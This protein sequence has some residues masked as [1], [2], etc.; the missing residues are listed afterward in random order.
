MSGHRHRALILSLLIVILAGPALARA[1]SIDY[2]GTYVWS[3]PDA[4]FGGFSAIEISE[5][6]TRFHALTDRAQIRWGEIERDAEGRIRALH[7]SG[8]AVLQDSQGRMLRP[9]W[10]GDSEGLALDPL[11]GGFWVSFEG[12]DRVAYYD[13]ADAPATRLPIAEGFRDLPVNRGL[14]ALA[15]DAHGTLY[16]L[17]EL[18]PEGGDAFPVW[19]FR[20]GVWDQPFSL[21]GNSAWQ[22]VGADIGPDGRLYL[23]ERSFQGILGFRSRIRRFSLSETGLSDEETLLESGRLQYDNLEGISAWDDGVGIRLTMISDDNF[24]SFQRTELV[25]YRIRD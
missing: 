3:L 8:R 21:P 12:L 6:G 5:G 24:M 23:L 9:G 4:D 19:R 14:E 13:D 17:P 16:T 11:G 22:A 20:D 7:V 10:Q 1:T 18:L 25:E 15:A 2:V